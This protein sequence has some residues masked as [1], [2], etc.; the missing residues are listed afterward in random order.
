VRP[1]TQSKSPIVPLIVTVI[2][3]VLI[4]GS[5]RALQPK[6]HTASESEIRA[7]L[8][9][10]L[11][12][13]SSLDIEAKARF[14]KLV[15]LASGP[16]LKTITQLGDPKV[17]LS[18]R[19]EIAGQFWQSNPKLLSDLNSLIESGPIQF[20]IGSTGVL[21]PSVLASIQSLSKLLTECAQLRAKQGDYPASVQLFTLCIKIDDRLRSSGGPLIAYLVAMSIDT[22]S[23]KEISKAVLLPGFPDSA[24][25]QLLTAMKPSPVTDEDLATAIRTDFQSY[26]YRQL[27]DPTKRFANADGG[28]A[29][30]DDAA[31]KEAIIGTYDALETAN[32]I[33]TTLRISLLNARRPLSQFD[34]SAS[35]LARKE[36][37]GIPAYVNTSASG[38]NSNTWDK[39]KYK[40][41]MNNIHNSIGRQ[42][43]SNDLMVGTGMV[44]LS[45]QWR[46]YHD[47]VRI[48]VA[49]RIFRSTHGG[50]LPKTKDELI[51]IL[52]AWPHDPYNGGQMF[53]DPKKEVAYSVGKNLVDDG[54]AIGDSLGSK[55]LGISLK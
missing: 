34:G 36:S 12:Q 40:L 13:G 14:K 44:Q 27:P 35:E 42:M 51:P 39:L 2:V 25:R 19:A 24:C 29:P 20:D 9:P 21:D 46:A 49:T 22:M 52:G 3:V 50:L 38:T 55:D 54:G 43:V 28:Q 17:G 16:D 6:I 7:L 53:Y 11:L 4:F 8:P 15:S 32:M 30:N 48:L 37:E 1:P 33:G 26:L 18:A 41:A 23:A 10:E 47:A 31:N 45:D 5:F